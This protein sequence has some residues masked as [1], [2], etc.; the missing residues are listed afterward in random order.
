M[1]YISLTPKPPWQAGGCYCQQ[2][3]RDREERENLKCCHM[4]HYLNSLKGCYIRGLIRDYS[5]RSLGYGSHEGLQQRGEGPC[6]G[7]IVAIYRD[8]RVYVGV[9]LG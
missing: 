9:T 7:D 4:S 2:F 6:K 1:P 5:T 8:Y 3:K